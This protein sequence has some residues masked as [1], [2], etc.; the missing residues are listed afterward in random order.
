MRKTRFVIGQFYHVYN[1]GVDKR[2][3]F[4][5][6][7][8]YQRFMDSISSFNDVE[9]IGHLS[10]NVVHD[11]DEIKNMLIQI[12]A[13]CL[14]PNH[15]H[16]LIEQKADDGISKFLHRLLTGYTMYF[17][18]R[19][20]RS[21]ALFQ[22]TFKSKHVKND[23]YLLQLSRYIHLNP[24]KIL[25]PECKEPTAA[26]RLLKMYPWSSYRDFCQQSGMNKEN[27]KNMIVDMVGGP[28]DYRKFVVEYV[29][30]NSLSNLNLSR[31]SLDKKGCGN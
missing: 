10:R 5:N 6:D 3:I 9:P 29:R 28:D 22:S 12:S 4:L 25:S 30:N 20:E 1:R 31:L 7:R 26:D 23:S 16:F 8:D 2:S 21:G 13:F 15:F 14:M 18:K 11:S 17:N 24:L 19:Y 27:R